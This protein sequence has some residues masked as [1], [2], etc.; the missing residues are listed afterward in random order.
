VLNFKW[1][2]GKFP[3]TTVLP[4]SQSAGTFR[5]PDNTIRDVKALGHSQ[6]YMQSSHSAIAR[7]TSGSMRDSPFRANEPHV[8]PE[9]VVCKWP[10]YNVMEPGDVVLTIEHCWGCKYHQTCT[11]HKE[12]MYLQVSFIH[13]FF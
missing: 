1:V 12:N 9:A 6:S 4:R 3:S 13:F 5:S 10:E 8:L 11:H 2:P 7:K